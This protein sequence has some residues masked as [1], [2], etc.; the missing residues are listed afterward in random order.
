MNAVESL[1]SLEFLCCFMPLFL[2]AQIRQGNIAAVR[3]ADEYMK[4]L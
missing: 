2:V 3:A 1:A 4:G